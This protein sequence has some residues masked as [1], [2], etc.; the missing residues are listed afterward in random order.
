MTQ[1]EQY[2]VGS[3]YA[4]GD[5]QAPPDRGDRRDS[6]PAGREPAVDL[7]VDQST[8]VPRAMGAFA[9][10]ASVADG[11]RRGLGRGRGQ[12]TDAAA[13]ALAAAAAARQGKA[14]RR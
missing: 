3:R 6:T 11:G 5:D 4:E 9:R 2:L 1:L 10:R 14:A 13:G 12:G 8:G 7:S